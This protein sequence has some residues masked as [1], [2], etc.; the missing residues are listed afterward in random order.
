[1]KN[2][3]YLDANI[4]IYAVINTDKEGE[5]CRKIL[6]KLVKNELD[7]HTSFITWD[8]FVHIIKKH[9]G[10]EI[11]I[12]EGNKFLEF[13]NLRFLKVN[14]DV[15]IKAQSLIS[16]Y[17]I[18]PRDAIH[19]ATALV[20]NINEIISNDKDFDTIKEI[21]RISLERFK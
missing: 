2:M 20:N 1:M 8:E 19:A 18:N 13:P 3:I 10:R 12:L 15:I 9:K 14:E 16:K 6:T 21:K 5:Y 17:S 4:F 7:G 11:A